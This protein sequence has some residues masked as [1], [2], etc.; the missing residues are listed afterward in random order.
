MNHMLQNCGRAEARSNLR[1]FSI[2]LV[3]MLLVVL[4]G[5]ELAQAAAPK[6][7]RRIY[8]SCHASPWIS[9]PAN[10]PNHTAWETWPGRNEQIRPQD[11]EIRRRF[12]EL[13]KNA[14]PDEALFIIPSYPAAGRPATEVELISEG[15]RLFGD[16]C[17][18]TSEGLP[19]PEALGGASF[20]AGLEQDKKL[21]QAA[22]AKSVDDAGFQHEFEAWV[23]AKSWITDLTRQLRAN[24][25][26]FDPA[27]VEFVCWGSDFRGCAATYPIM[28]GRALNLAHPIERR[29]DMIV[30]DE[31]T[32]VVSS[33][34]V[35]QNVKVDD[36]ARLFI[37]KNQ[38]GRYCADFWEGTHGPMD[39]ARQ[40]TLKFPPDSVRL[41]NWH[42]DSIG[43]T[44]TDGTVTVG[45]GC[46]GHTPHRETIIEANDNL[47]LD[48]FYA[49][50]VS[51]KI[52]EKP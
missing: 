4:C 49:A 11:F 15:K 17:L 34:L 42:G 35:M 10:D 9:E 20:A 44:E 32:M 7:I 19:S 30:H 33:T 48:D 1:P 18:V 13:M 2:A 43:A 52:T 24:G 39:R 47:S 46:G 22:R 36:N 29:W 6:V 21:A 38:Q 16:R 41:V 26:D 40:I 5:A 51:G 31:G 45:I 3:L 50:L 8:L 27:T 37:F 25:Y 12:Y 23:R 28:M 14:G